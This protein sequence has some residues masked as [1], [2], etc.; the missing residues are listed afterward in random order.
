MNKHCY[1]LVFNRARGILLAVGECARSVGKSASGQGSRAI[2]VASLLL[3]GP[4]LAQVVADPNAPGSQRPQIV[5]TASG[6][7]QVNIQTPSAAGVSRNVYSQF[8][9]QSQGLILNNSKTD[10]QTQLG[11]WVQGNGNLAGG[12]AR[13]ILNEI[14]S[15]NPSQLRG[16]VEVAG[17]RADV[18]IANPSGIVV[19]GGG[20]I[21]ASGVTLSTGAA[22]LNASTGAIDSYRIQ[23]GTI[24]FE[25]SG[26]DTRTADYTAILARAI[27][28]NAG[29]WAQE[30]KAV[31]GA[32][33]VN[34]ASLQAGQALSAT[35]ITPATGSTT[36]SF[37]LDVAAVGGM[38]AG[39]IYL[40][41]T[42]AGLGVNNRGTIGATAGDVVVLADGTLTN[43]GQIQASNNLTLRTTHLDNT[44]NL[45][46]DGTLSA[47]ATD[48]Q[49]SISNRG[50]GSII[51]GSVTLQATRSISNTGPQALIGATDAAGQLVLLSD[52]I[53][54]ADDVTATDAMPTTTIY[55]AGEVVL[56]GGVDSNG[57]YTRAGSITNRSGL[58][59]SGG[60]MTLAAQ[61][62]TNTR[63]TLVMGST[64]DQ[65]V[66][67]TVI[68]ALSISLSG[69]VGQINTPNPNNIG[70]VYIDPPHGGSMN[71]D[72]LYTTYSGTAGQNAV[73]D[74]SPAAQIISG[75][76]LTFAADTLQNR[77]SRIAS[78]RDIDLGNATLDQESWQGAE[79][80]R[81]KVAYSGSYIYRTYRG[82]IW[83]HTFCDSGCS[84]GGDTRYYVRNDYE[85]SLTATGT[86]RGAGGTIINGTSSTG[87]VAPPPSTVRNPSLT[88]PGGGLFQVTGN[89]SANYLIESDPRFTSHQ[90]WLSSDYLLSALSLDPS[91]TQKR[92]GDG[93]YEQRLVREQLLELT[94][95]QFL[96][97]ASSVQDSY[98]AL[99]NNAV[100]Y[101]QAL[102]LRPGIALSAEQM[103]Q[104]T[105]DIVWLVEREVTLPDGSKTTALVP[106]VYLSQISLNN[107]SRDG[108]LIAAADIDLQGLQGLSNGGTIQASRD[109]ALQALSDL[110]V[111]G[112]TLSAGRQM[113]VYADG[114]IN[115]DSAKLQA[116]TLTLG[117]GQDLRMET[118]TSTHTTQSGKLTTLGR[119]TSVTVTGDATI[120]SGGDTQLIGANLTVGGNLDLQTG[121][122]LDIGT[123]QTR[124]TKTVQRFGGSASSDFTQNI[125]SSVVVGGNTKVD[126]TG[127]MIVAGSALQL[128]SQAGNTAVLNAGGDVTLTAV[129]DS[130]R[131]DSSWNTS[132]GSQGISSKGQYS[133]YDEAVLGANLATGGSLSI[134][135][136]KDVN[137]AGSAINAAGLAVV[138]AVGDINIGTVEEQHA[139]SLQAQGSK[140]GLMR[141]SQSEERN[142]QASTLAQ[143]SS[144]SGQ[145]LSLQAGQDVNVTA[146][147]VMAEDALQ[148]KT[149]RDVNVLAGY[150]TQ[151]SSSYSQTT[152]SAG[153]LAKAVG[154]TLAMADLV[155]TVAPGTGTQ[156][157]VATLL[158]REQQQHETVQSSTTV[159]S[160]NL[161]GGTVQIESGRD[162]TLQAA[163]VVADG[164]VSVQAA[165]DIK[166]LAAEQT[167]QS[168]QNSETDKS[169]LLSQKLLSTSVGKSEQ[170][171]QEQNNSTTSVVTQIA[172]LGQ[173]SL[174]QVVANA[175]VQIQAQGSVSGE[176]AQV[177]APA[178]DITVQGSSVELLE[179]RNEVSTASQQS[180]KTTAVTSQVGSSLVSAVQN[181]DRAAELRSQAKESGDKRTQMLADLNVAMAAYNAYGTAN[182]GGGNP[183]APTPQA[184]PTA[185]FTA[186]TSIGA[187]QSSS[188]S[189]QSQSTGTQGQI[190]AGGDIHISAVGAGQASNLTLQGQNVQAGGQ[191]AL[192][193]DHQVNLLASQDT[194]SQQSSNNA[195][196]GAVGVT[197]SAGGN[198]NGFSF[199]LSA[200]KALGKADGDSTIY[201]NTHVSGDSV[202]IKSG[203]DTTLK[204]AVI[205]AREVSADVGG[206]LRIE[207]LQ[208]Q[209]VYTDKQSSSGAGVSLCI[210]PIC[211]GDM[212]V[213]N[214]SVAKAKIDS[215]YLSV[216]EQSAIRAGDGGFQVK[217]GGDTTLTGAQIAST[218]AAIDDGKNSFST[219]GTLTTQDLQNQAAYDA[220][221]YSVS[222]STAGGGAGGYGSD[223]GSASSTS[224][225]GISGIAG[226]T[227]ART[228][229]AET[230]IKPIFDAAKVKQDIQLQTAVTAEFGR[231]ASKA[232]G[233]Y[234]EKQLKK[235]KENND[236]EGMDAWKEGGSARVALHAVVGG[237]TLGA[238][239]AI[240]A[241]GSQVVID[242]IG[243]AIKESDL[244]LPLKTTLVAVAGTAIGVATGGAAG[245]TTAFNA[246][247]NNYLKHTELKTKQE[248]LAACTDDACRKEV[249]SQ[250]DKVSQERNAEMV[251]SCL[252]SGAAQCH[253]NIDQMNLDLAQLKASGGDYSKGITGFTPEERNNIK[254]AMNQMTTNLE[255]LAA[256][257]NKRLGT[258]YSS[259]DDL[260]KTGILSVQEGEL[261]KAARADS[262]VNFLGAVI[263]PSGAKSSP[264][265]SA[266]KNS[267]NEFVPAP[268]NTV[269]AT[270]KAPVDGDFETQ[271]LKNIDPMRLPDGVKMVRELEKSGVSTEDA[272]R[273][274]QGYISSGSTPPVATPLD[275]TDKL[276]KVVP[277]GGAP[278]ANSGYWMTESQLKNLQQNP[279]ELSNKLGLPPNMQVSSYDIFEIKPRQGALAFEST[280]AP[281]TVNGV[282]DTVGGAK[283]MIVVDRNQF[284]PPVKTG[285]ITTQ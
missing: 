50:S 6:V 224:T 280:I 176:G 23:Q 240:G 118:L 232:V 149:G 106:Q 132:G 87:L 104:L 119:Q 187:S 239:G 230:G 60:S 5:N 253:A 160:S 19:N 147:D 227:G 14:N 89:P 209:A 66:D 25:G 101:A 90:Q 200:N 275:I 283:Q 13:V 80:A 242:Q 47:T 38:Y 133:T 193:A 18:V 241:V 8:D 74:I 278:G 58:I 208:D 243:Q 46:A 82:D 188:Q 265:A 203:D 276:V 166:L 73:Q 238:Q 92:L 234:A 199:Q 30:L 71:S 140:S 201:N 121:G 96:A 198:Q 145:S 125:G 157:T 88:L 95:R 130:G 277:S 167:S 131:I 219:G 85:S 93:Y 41:G 24:R 254:Q 285:S 51:G 165:G 54:N 171:Y 102:D 70:G 28:V 148:L 122:D 15:A 194:A 274:A 249:N 158:T 97:G 116:A 269:K 190:V 175:H 169:G 141:A 228:G 40:V 218:Q 222:T 81:I 34:A 22:Q 281:T 76:D 84:A 52:S 32:S 235:A 168:K 11:G 150:D 185:G 173:D 258:T 126:V 68:T 36:P 256:E 163:Q 75:S 220:T 7:T 248:Q 110:S 26:L 62:I 247:T 155:G 186:G 284:T 134:N 3:A 211:V 225:A 10:V 146:S 120:S 9:V 16:Y 172:S 191:V 154:T 181:V 261:L 35:A 17:Q 143:G 113:T 48:A 136:G 272:K 115:L 108:A 39:K 152:S 117:A 263:L 72:Y 255:I 233:D 204:G 250:W 197:F 137:V 183:D 202:S 114:H 57:A 231:N 184:G 266:S 127:D 192:S 207:S 65:A 268:G 159:R 214:I 112:G 153:K 79:R 105:S 78:G 177:V 99:L 56:A 162:T 61:T 271:G 236:K 262:M 86:I 107:L 164:Q 151:A 244:P 142:S 195:S 251:S 94:G 270:A 139:S 12:S 215:D 135:A 252:S 257:G 260:V 273:I 4:V 31:A 77:W 223:S 129:K 59:E 282:P 2:T 128:G 100:T 210:P 91:A 205:T 103:A 264:P 55:G 98:Q 45:V 64:Y 27:E 246:T 221:S 180:S 216:G 21:N 33:Q 174:G 245:A 144:L 182:G 42:E 69:T 178:G 138:Q 49:G 237:L 109:L 63:R 179:A 226:D 83:S 213:V 259:P 37:A 212:A 267:V 53:T 170:D 217:V 196:G 67:P 123:A 156:F 189:Q 44:G 1:R 43:S 279:A 20:F 206:N 124:E 29:I 161:S 229:D 111:T